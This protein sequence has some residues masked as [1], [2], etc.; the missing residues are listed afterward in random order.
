[1]SFN[2]TLGKLK[3]KKSFKFIMLNIGM[4]DAKLSRL[5]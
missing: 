2:F 5:N 4:F 1:M 3:N